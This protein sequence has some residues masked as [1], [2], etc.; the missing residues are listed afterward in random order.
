MATADTSAKSARREWTPHM[1]QGMEFFAWVRLL[2][3]NR[4]AIHFSCLYVA[5]IASVVSLFHSLLRLAEEVVYGNRIR[6]TTLTN[7][8]L[9]IIGHWRTGTTLL[10]ELLILDDRHSYPTTYQCLDPNHFLLTERF[11]TR[12]LWFLVPH[13]R[14]MDNM[15]AGWNRPQEDEFALTMM[16]A[17]SPYLTIAFPNHPPQHQD[18]FDLENLSPSAQAL[19]KRRFLHF[20]RRLTLRNPK[21]LILKSPTHT[22]RIKALLDL[23]PNAR[24]VHIVRDP[25]VVFPSTVNLWKS[26]YYTH[27]LQVPTYAG[28]DEY[29]FQTFTELYSKLEETRS[30]IVPSRFHELRYEDLVRDPIGEMRL[31]YEHLKLD[32]FETVLPKM[33]QYLDQ[34]AG[35][36][37]NRYELPAELREE[38]T[39]RWG[40]V[41]KRYGYAPKSLPSKTA[42]EPKTPFPISAVPAPISL[43]RVRSSPVDGRPTEM[44]PHSAVR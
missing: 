38:I 4:F 35:Y 21:R 40:A 33:E 8:P 43:P 14:P 7:A 26:L 1:W 13:H 17:P 28:V 20:L 11:L 44:Q 18:A 23:F 25:Y 10:H 2:A 16:G 31:L 41:I 15:A 27:G 39:R 34:V 3:R 5:V 24:F 36:Q 6:R 9:F 19:W 30:L 22:F 29:V 37:T 32:G 42:P 12:C